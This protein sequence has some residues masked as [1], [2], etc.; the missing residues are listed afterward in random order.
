MCFELTLN[1]S[2]PP[3]RRWNNNS[4]HPIQFR[5]NRTPISAHAW[6]ACPNT[7]AYTQAHAHAHAHARTRTRAHTHT[8]TC[9]RTRTRNAHTHTHTHFR[10]HF[11][12]LTETASH[13]A[14]NRSR[15]P[16]FRPRQEYL[17]QQFPKQSTKQSTKHGSFSY[18]RTRSNTWAT[19][20]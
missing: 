13:I 11:F 1:N 8:R 15:K 4:N 9:T 14:L 18:L 10:Y 12:A 16:H 2:G 20:T 17:W 5:I 3:S 7:H 6:T 19:H